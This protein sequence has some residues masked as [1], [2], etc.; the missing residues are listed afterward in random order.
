LLS[1]TKNARNPL[2]EVDYDYP[3]PRE[4]WNG[5]VL[6][7]EAPGH[8]EVKQGRPFVGRSGQLLNETLTEGGIERARC[9]V[10]N[11]FRIRPPDNKVDHFFAS[12]R[13]AQQQNLTIIEELG[14]FGSSWCKGDYA[15]EIQHL[16]E[17][18]HQWRPRMIVALGRTPFWALSGGNGIIANAGRLFDCRLLP[19]TKVIPTFHPSYILRGNWS[20]RPEWLEHFLAAAHYV[21][22]K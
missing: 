10:S 4:S 20:K 9:L 18:L 19:G 7:G 3:Q 2:P 12:K 22:E 16:R 8:E 6:V 15:S 5:L 13:A 1:S 14:P 21:A 17:V 11:V